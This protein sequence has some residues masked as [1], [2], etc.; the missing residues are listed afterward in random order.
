LDI[1]PAT[2]NSPA[3]PR[4]A[5]ADATKITSDYSTFLR[6]L[7]TQL[8]N[9]DPLNPIESSDYAVQL[10]TFSGVEQQTRTNQLLEALATQFNM[11][12]MAQMAGWVG[13]EARVDAPVWMDGDPVTLSPNPATG[14]DR[15]VLVVKDSRG[16][17]VARQDLAPSTEPY[18]WTGLGIDGLPLRSGQYTL[19]LESYRNDEMISLTPMEHYARI[20]EAQGGATGTTLLLEG[21][22]RVAA[23][24]ITALRGG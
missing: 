8:Q 21:G 20:V 7:T 24:K 18:L 15:A 12:G 23:D 11:L 2:A 22:V 13:Q 3:A 9:Q 14:A 6:M 4:Q 19:S 17:V 16:T 1:Q 10:A 5:D